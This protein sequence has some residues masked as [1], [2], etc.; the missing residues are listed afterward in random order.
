MRRRLNDAR[1]AHDEA[2]QAREDAIVAAYKAGGGMR[3]IADQ[4]GFSHPGVSK[5]L[6]RLGVRRRDMTAEE[7]RADMDRRGQL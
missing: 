6:E 3:E 1:D 2:V 4:V 7:L 5:L